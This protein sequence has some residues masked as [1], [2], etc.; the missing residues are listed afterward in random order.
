MLSAQVELDRWEGYMTDEFVVGKEFT[1]ADAALAPYLANI[2]RYGVDMS[3]FPRLDA[4]L[5]RMEVR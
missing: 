5:K 3:K 2:Q 1:L 4:Y